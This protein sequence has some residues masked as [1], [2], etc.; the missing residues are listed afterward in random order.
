MRTVRIVVLL[1]CF[2]QTMAQAKEKVMI[3]S[4]GDV[5]MG[6]EKGVARLDTPDKV[7]EQAGIWKARGVDKVLFRIDDFGSL[8]FFNVMASTPGHQKWFRITKEAW[9]AGLVQ[10]A[11][12]AIRSEGVKAYMW[13]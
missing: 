10:T 3:I 2:A 13:G 11:V 9:D 12:E 1:C 7:R 8:L 4:W 6:D 5:I